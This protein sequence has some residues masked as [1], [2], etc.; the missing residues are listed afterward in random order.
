MCCVLVCFDQI[1]ENWSLTT[2][3]NICRT[4]ETGGESLAPLG[5]RFDSVSPCP[6]TLPK[7]FGKHPFIEDAMCLCLS[8]S[9]RSMFSCKITLSASAELLAQVLEEV[10]CSKTLAFEDGEELSLDE[11]PL[12]HNNNGLFLADFNIIN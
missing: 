5:N 8:V 4:E 1:R 3:A 11:T 9:T 2:V 10:C 12:L 7:P 6:L